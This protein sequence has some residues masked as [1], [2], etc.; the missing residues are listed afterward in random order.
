MYFEGEPGVI[1]DPLEG[2]LLREGKLIYIWD[3]ECQS[4]SVVVSSSKLYVC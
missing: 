3:R 1:G 2:V 4:W